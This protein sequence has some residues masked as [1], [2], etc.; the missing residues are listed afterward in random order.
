MTGHLE[1]C[2][3]DKIE[4]R[5]PNQVPDEPK[6]EKEEN[7]SD[8]EHSGTYL[9]KRLNHLFNIPSKGVYTVLELVRDSTGIIE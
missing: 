9:V 4:V 3:G 8:P 7:V 2:A 5:I 6:E 1:L